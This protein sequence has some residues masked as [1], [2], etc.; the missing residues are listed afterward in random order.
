MDPDSLSTAQHPYLYL[1]Q[2]LEALPHCRM[3]AVSTLEG[4]DPWWL[5]EILGSNACSA[6]CEESC[7]FNAGSGAQNA[8]LSFRLKRTDIEEVHV[9]GDDQYY[10]AV[11]EVIRL[12]DR[13]HDERW[14]QDS[15]AHAAELMQS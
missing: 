5:H 12:C 7:S 2:V 13:L 1:M 9:A 3:R 6:E 15:V 4:A 11:D 14:D 10:D 8:E